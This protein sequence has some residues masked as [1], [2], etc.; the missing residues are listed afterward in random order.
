MA[1]SISEVERVQIR[2]TVTPAI[3]FGA[4]RAIARHVKW[5]QLGGYFVVFVFPLGMIAITRGR[6]QQPPRRL[7]DV[8]LS[9]RVW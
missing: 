8:T 2:F 4:Q 5:M 9:H 3:L 6:D 1:I 7:P